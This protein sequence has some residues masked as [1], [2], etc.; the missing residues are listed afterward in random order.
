MKVILDENKIN[1]TIKE[2][3]LILKSPIGIVPHGSTHKFGGVD[4]I[5]LDELGEPGDNTNLNVSTEHHGLVP[6]LPGDSNKFLNG[7]G[8]WSEIQIPTLDW[9]NIANKPST[10]QPSAHQHNKSD[11]INFSV[12]WSEIV[13]KPLEFTPAPHVH[14]QSEITNLE[15]S[16]DEL[17][18]RAYF[19]GVG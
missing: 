10:F 9:D 13:D 16:L 3:N 12:L 18:R 17:K 6:K 7:T 8:N 15:A 1:T 4:I 14:S 5:K 19:Y 2:N 11:I